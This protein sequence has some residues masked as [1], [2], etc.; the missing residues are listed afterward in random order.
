MIAIKTVSNEMVYLIMNA[1][2]IIIILM[3]SVNSGHEI[4]NDT[5][6]NKK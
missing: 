3:L 5:K 6:V 4:M 1:L 2:L